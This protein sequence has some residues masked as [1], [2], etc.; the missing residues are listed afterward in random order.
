MH[1]F[2]FRLDANRCVLKRA[3][4]SSLAV[5]SFFESNFVSTADSHRTE[6]LF[7]TPIA[8]SQKTSRR[9]RV[10]FEGCSFRKTVR[11]APVLARNVRTHHAVAQRTV[12]RQWIASVSFSP[13]LLR[14]RG[15]RLNL[16]L[17]HVT[18]HLFYLQLDLCARR[19]DAS[20]LFLSAARARL[21]EGKLAYT[22]ACEFT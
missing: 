14:T 12:L 18:W 21:T 13:P 16:R 10:R 20:D 7:S 5:V 11:V 19:P 22:A 8:N 17:T 3:R 6:N 9:F 4:T 15:G 2:S 1:E